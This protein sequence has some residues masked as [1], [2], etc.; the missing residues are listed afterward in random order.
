MVLD[1]L[2]I[3]LSCL[4]LSGGVSRETENRETSQKIE[5]REQN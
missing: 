4:V 1:F 3:E 5:W 2:R